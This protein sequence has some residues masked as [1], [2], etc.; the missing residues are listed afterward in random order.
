MVDTGSYLFFGSFWFHLPIGGRRGCTLGG[1]GALFCTFVFYCVF[2]FFGFFVFFLCFFV[3]YFL[4]LVF[5]VSPRL[6]VDAVAHW[7]VTVRCFFFIFLLV[8][9]F[10]LCLFLHF[11]FYLPIGGRRGCTLGGDGAV[12][13]HKN[14][15]SIRGF[16]SWT[17]PGNENLREL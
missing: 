3:F 6:V 4:S 15:T 14:K 12:S 17:R 10:S 11:L 9:L 13:R 1:D 16:D 2:Y 5:L 7:A 8:S